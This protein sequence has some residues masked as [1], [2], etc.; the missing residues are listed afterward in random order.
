MDP[1]VLVVYYS[2]T[3]NTE[4]MARAVARGVE[5]QGMTVEAK[6]VEETSPEDLFDADG[7]IMGSPTYYGTMAAPI[8]ALIDESVKYHGRLQG[9]VGG[10]FSSS[11]RAGGGNE[12]TV[13]S[14][15]EALL[16]HGMIVQGTAKGD[17]YGPVALGAPDDDSE[18]QCVDL[19]ARVA[20]LVKALSKSR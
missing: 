16:I 17:H 14:I 20:R 19:G 12:T 3:G 18:A 1:R 10:A 8:K 15:L 13:L 6:R 9:K 7:I 5:A 4:K 11:Q 2:K